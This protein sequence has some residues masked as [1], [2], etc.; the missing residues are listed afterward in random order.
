MCIGNFEIKRFNQLETKLLIG[1]LRFQMKATIQIN[2]TSKRE[3]GLNIL[4]FELLHLVVGF[5]LVF[6]TLLIVGK[7]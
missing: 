1:K 3:F 4:N 5:L 7:N 2:T 6:G